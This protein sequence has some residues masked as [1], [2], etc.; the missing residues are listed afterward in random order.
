MRNI[1]IPNRYKISYHSI[2]N[3]DNKNYF[4]HECKGYGPKGYATNE[5]EDNFIEIHKE[6]VDM[7]W[8]EL[9]W[10]QSNANSVKKK[11][12]KNVKRRSAEVKRYT[13]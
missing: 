5:Y 12:I 13:W 7:F 4:N 6:E 9:G 8:F 10:T 11:G 1:K 2:Q 3:K